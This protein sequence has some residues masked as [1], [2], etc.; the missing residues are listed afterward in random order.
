MSWASFIKKNAAL[1]SVCCWPN[2]AFFLS[3]STR[4]WAPY[5]SHHGNSSFGALLF[6]AGPPPQGAA[7][8]DEMRRAEA[9]NE[10]FFL[11]S[12]FCILAPAV[13]VGSF[14]GGFGKRRRGY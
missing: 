9:E 12:T 7:R 3:R 14:G 5:L 10:H 13:Y 11:R 4:E 1:L 6:R 8:R 2:C